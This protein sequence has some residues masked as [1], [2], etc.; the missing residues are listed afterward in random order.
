MYADALNIIHFIDTNI[1][2]QSK[3]GL[4]KNPA[5]H[6]VSSWKCDAKEH[7]KFSDIVIEYT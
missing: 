4:S 3:F 7:D 2:L 6:I 1:L 5:L